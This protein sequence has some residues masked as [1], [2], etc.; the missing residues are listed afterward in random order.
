M[1]NLGDMMK[2]L[3]GGLGYQSTMHRVINKSSADRYSIVFFFDGNV[4]FKLRPLGD[5]VVDEKDVMT[6]E[7][8][9]MN[10]VKFSWGR[11]ALKNGIGSTSE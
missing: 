8:Y 6:V 2:K 10:R 1:V 4:D 9:M 3:L 7:E 5:E 11:H